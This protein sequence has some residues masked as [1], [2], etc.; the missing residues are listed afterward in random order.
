MSLQYPTDPELAAWLEA[1]PKTETHLHME[2]ALPWELLHRRNPQAYGERPAA[3]RPGFR[4]RDFAHF[5]NELLG[6]AVP[7]FKSPEAY[8]RSAAAVFGRLVS[9]NV[10][11]VET[12]FHSGIIAFTGMPAAE[13]LHAIHQAAPRGLTVRVYVGLTRDIYRGNMIPVLDDLGNWPGLAGIDL[14]G[15]EDLPLE[16]WTAPF[17]AAAGAAGLE[18]KAHAGESG[19]AANVRE[20]IEVLGV[21]RIQHGLRA[22]DDPAVLELARA[23]GTT[24]DVCPISN[25]RLAPGVTSLADHPLRALRAAGVHCTIS[26]DDPLCFGQCLTDEYAALATEGGFSRRELVELARHGFEVGTMP[27]AV[28]TAALAQLTAIEQALPHE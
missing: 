14:H 2:G 1:L 5:E 17:W 7:W 8:Y 13:I 21:R 24:F 25:A 23:T 4:Y 22:V 6:W 11:Y 18:L 27:A 19:P 20:A 3:H 16:D 15:R 28:K 9:E 12:S 10:R 26:T